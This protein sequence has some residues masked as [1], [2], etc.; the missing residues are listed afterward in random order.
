MG[1][2]EDRVNWQNPGPAAP[3][4]DVVSV[5]AGRS[6]A[7]LDASLRQAQ[8]DDRGRG[9]FAPVRLSGIGPRPGG[10]LSHDCFQ[11]SPFLADVGDVAERS[12]SRSV[13]PLSRWRVS[14]LRGVLDRLTVSSM[15][16]QARN[17]EPNYR[18]RSCGTLISGR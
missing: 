8:G 3:G 16:E 12:A 4:G 13:R 11:R 7:N 18:L 9:K 5:V 10:E 1:R 14:V 6:V 2:T 15:Q 17:N